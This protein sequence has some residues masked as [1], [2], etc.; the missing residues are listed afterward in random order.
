MEAKVV[1]RPA[2]DLFVV[3]VLSLLYLIV[4]LAG[5]GGLLRNS[6]GLPF[7]LVLPG[8]AMLAAIDSDSVEL[9]LTERLSL[10]C[11][12]SLV[13]VI[14]VASGLN[15]IR[16]LDAA[17]LAWVLEA[18]IVAS[19]ARA[20]WYRTKG[21]PTG[22]GHLV[23]LPL[24][25]KNGSALAIMIHLAA[26]GCVCATFCLMADV[27]QFERVPVPTTALYLL[28]DES[29]AEGYVERVAC[30]SRFRVTVGVI[31]N[32]RTAQEYSIRMQVD[33]QPAQILTPIT[34]DPGEIWEEPAEVI[35]DRCGTMQSVAFHLLKGESES[36][37]RSVHQRVRVT[38][39]G[40]RDGVRE[41]STAFGF[42]ANG[43]WL[44]R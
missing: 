25:G 32:E 43:G 13:S 17:R 38:A 7:A 29:R 34:L 4:V 40:E 42:Q 22:G 30:G 44:R 35:L 14:S 39:D 19:C 9:D 10:S 2:N 28:G 15:V 8:Y 26:I 41:E 24:R 36:P 3:L 16:R 31:N 12:L 20:Y 6:L 27:G 5:Y 33:D 21:S 37:D 1:S 23:R 11:M 18:I